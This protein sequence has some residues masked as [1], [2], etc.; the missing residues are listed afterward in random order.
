[1]EIAEEGKNE[2][3]KSQPKNDKIY[4]KTMMKFFEL[5][6]KR[7]YDKSAFVR[8]KALKVSARIIR[9]PAIKL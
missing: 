4:E 8:A 7:F 1:M 5:I 6:A 3:K 9:Q 2:E